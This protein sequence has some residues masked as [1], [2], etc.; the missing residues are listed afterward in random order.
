MENEE[1]FKFSC[2]YCKHDKS[3]N[4]KMITKCQN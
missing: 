2:K 1:N 3:E 4:K